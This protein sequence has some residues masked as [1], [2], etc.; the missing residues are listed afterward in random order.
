MRTQVPGVLSL[1]LLVGLLTG[2]QAARSSAGTSSDVAATAEKERQ[3]R[4][5]RAGR[6]LNA[7]DIRASDVTRV[8]ELFAGR[9]PGVQVLRHPGGGISLRI[10]GATSVLGSNEPLYVIDGFPIEA[11]PGGALVG[12][13]PADI[14]RI[15]VL[16][17]IGSTSFYGMRGANG[18]V[19]ITTKNTR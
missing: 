12:L 17:D 1:A 18:V 9:F 7:D 16:K 15:E 14:Q 19:V 6:S 11:P 8:E 13:N 2:C 5:D 4:A 10:R 3:K